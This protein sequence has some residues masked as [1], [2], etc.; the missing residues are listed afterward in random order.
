MYLSYLDIGSR[1]VATCSYE[2]VVL[3]LF[4]YMQHQCVQYETERIISY[5]HTQQNKCFT[6]AGLQTVKSAA[7]LQIDTLQCSANIIFS[8]YGYSNMPTYT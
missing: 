3:P 5:S 2:A 8:S 4:P 6:P 1:G 7:I